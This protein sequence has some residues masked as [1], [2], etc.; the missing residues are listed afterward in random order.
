MSAKKL[1]LDAKSAHTPTPWVSYKNP[2]YI[3]RAGSFE[4]IAECSN[5][6][7]STSEA[8]ANVER[9]VSCVNLHDELVNTIALLVAK[10]AVMTDSEN[11]AESE[12]II[13][14]IELLQRVQ[15]AAK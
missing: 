9:I 11:P 10:A 4:L 6:N 8:I 3:K 12:T 14:A 2:T 5:K 13:D 1:N 7:V 15:R